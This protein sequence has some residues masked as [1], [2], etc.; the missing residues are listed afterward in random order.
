MNGFSSYSAQSSAFQTGRS[1][2]SRLLEDALA[3][4]AKED[5]RVGAFV[6]LNVDGARR[7]AAESTSR[8]LAGKP[9]SPLDGVLVGVKDIIE[10]RDMPTGQGSPMWEGFATNRDAASVQALREAGAVILGKTATT[11]FASTELYAKT[12]NP[13]DSKR[14]PGGS[15][16]G[17]A[18]A[19]GAGFLPLA[20]GSQVVG[21][22]VRPA[23]YCGCFGYKPTFGALNRSGSYDHLSQSCVGI[24]GATL[25]DVW[26]CAR[27]IASRVGGDP[28]HAGLSGPDELPAAQAPRK[29]VVLETDGWRKSTSGAREAFAAARERMSGQGIELA[30]RNSDPK[31]DAFEGLIAGALDLTWIMM[32]WEFRWPLATYE[33]RAASQVSAAM[34]ARLRQAEAMTQRDY[35]DALERRVRIR[36]AFADLMTNYDGAVTLAATGA[37]PASFETT[38]H[39]GFNVPASLLGVPAVSLPVLEDEGMPLGLQLIG[40]ANGD[41]E[42]FAM[43]RRICEQR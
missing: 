29:L 4:I 8:W 26:L 12:T 20:L 35:A 23:S 25:E 14:T 11:E 27:A 21:S 5:D 13:H 24:L 43:A 7:A 40:R 16:S 6:A 38:G 22:T 2:P 18:A 19:V 33:Q 17:S 3:L 31:I 32:A 30:D 39:P 9:L 28:G 1:S 10:T 41:A 15:S 34:L 36:Q 42:L 37:A